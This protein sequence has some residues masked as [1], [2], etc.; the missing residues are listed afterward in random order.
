MENC[1]DLPASAPGVRHGAGTLPNPRRSADRFP[2]S[3][4]PASANVPGAPIPP[5]STPHPHLS[6]LRL[7]RPRLRPTRE[8]RLAVE[9]VRS[10]SWAK[11]RGPRAA[12]NP[13]CAN[14]ALGAWSSVLCPQSASSRA[15]L[16]LLHDVFA[17]KPASLSTVVSKSVAHFGFRTRWLRLRVAPPERLVR[18][19]GRQRA[20]LR[21]SGRRS[22]HV[23]QLCIRR[24][25]ENYTT[26][27]ARFS[28]AFK[29]RRREHSRAM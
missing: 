2:V 10:C 9:P 20:D 3:R 12:V 8:K 24:L 21:V 14:F 17:L 1:S 16:A 28:F 13:G 11:R 22:P 29:E 5:N 25:P 6:R 18:R 4:G 27:R 7:A 19:R 23:G 15:N 26:D